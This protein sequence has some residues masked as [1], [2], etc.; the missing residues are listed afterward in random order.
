MTT[1][2]AM[3][4]D[5]MGK[6]SCAQCD[7]TIDAGDY[8]VVVM[9][10]EM[11]PH[12]AGGGRGVSTALSFCDACVSEMPTF[13][14]T[15]WLKLRSDA[16]AEPSAGPATEDVLRC[17][18]QSG[19]GSTK[20]EKKEGPTV[21]MGSD[22]TGD[23]D[24]KDGDNLARADREAIKFS[25]WVGEGQAAERSEAPPTVRRTVESVR[26]ETLGK[27]LTDRKSWGTMKGKGREAVTLYADG[28]SQSE[29]AR[30]LGVDQATV[31]RMIQGALKMAGATS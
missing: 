25:D 26:R 21:E 28:M 5:P 29:I 22:G 20:K 12:Y 9:A 7:G 1:T 4:V 18:P 19:N 8:R 17:H 2:P 10:V 31:S 13:E 24:A 27:F 16:A 23:D 14:L 3:G 30:K 15:N 11:K 6:T